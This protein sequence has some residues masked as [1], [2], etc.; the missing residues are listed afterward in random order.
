MRRIDVKTGAFATAVVGILSLGI[1]LSGC[2]GIDAEKETEPANPP[3]V[4]ATREPS[5]SQTAGGVTA[6]KTTTGP[7]GTGSGKTTPA[8]GSP[9]VSSSPSR[10]TRPPE[11]NVCM[12]LS[13]D[14][15][16]IKK[17]DAFNIEVLLTSD[18]Q[19][20]GAQCGLEFDPA[21]MECREVEEGQYFKEWAAA[22]N[23]S[24]MMFPGP[25]IDNEEGSVSSFA[26]ILTGQTEAELE[27]EDPEGAS[28]EGIFCSFSM[29]AKQDITDI[30]SLKLVDAILSN[31]DLQSIRDFEIDYTGYSSCRGF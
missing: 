3:A 1:L 10:T 18:I 7:A 24:T 25:K 13:I 4:T 28:G 11:T 14:D 12:S 19:L 17:G 31:T 9:D 29:T 2:S 8:T 26:I 30:T 23:V 27:G 6:E 21:L 15:E 22:K 20:K 16:D 5:A